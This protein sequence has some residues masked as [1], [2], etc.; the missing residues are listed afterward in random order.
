[1][2]I[3][4]GRMG[5][6]RRDLQRRPEPGDCPDAPQ[7]NG[8]SGTTNALALLDRAPNDKPW[9]LEVN[10]QNPHHPWDVTESMHRWYREPPV[11]FPLPLFNTEGI[12]PETH[13]EVRR[14][15]AATV[16]HLDRCLGRLVE[17]VGR[18]G[19]LE[20][21]VVVFTSDHGEMPGDY[22]QWQKLS[23]LQASV[24][25]PLAIAGPG[26]AA[27]GR[28]DAPMTTLDLTAS[29]LEWAGLTPDA[30]LDSRS[31]VSYLEG[32]GSK[33]R[34]VVFSGLSAWRMVFDGRFKLARGYDPGKRIGGHTF[35]PMHIPPDET[36]RLQRQ[37]PPILYDLERNER[38]DV[39]SAFPE[40]LHRLGAALDEH[41]AL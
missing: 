35:E 19:D 17:H 15:W 2:Y 6:F 1:M 26:V 28:D 31:L 16:E 25:V 27:V 18:R 38:D 41:L 33:H 32:G 8:S 10:L 22:N 12:S 30:G 39:S 21:T 23:P 34:D 37:R 13:Q 5:F 20:N 9:Y 7:R 40:V 11:D 3:I 4:P 14:N 29:F 24:G 36:R